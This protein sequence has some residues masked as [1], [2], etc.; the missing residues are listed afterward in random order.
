MADET[1]LPRRDTAERLALVAVPTLLGVVLAATSSAFD[2]PLT[3]LVL[4]GVIGLR[5]SRARSHYRAVRTADGIERRRRPPEE[6]WMYRVAQIDYDERWDRVLA[7]VAL[8][9]GIG[10]FVAVP[11]VDVEP[12]DRARLTVLGLGGI[13]VAAMTY[14][15]L[16]V[17]D[18]AGSENGAGSE[19]TDG[20][21]SE[22]R[23]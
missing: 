19:R 9:V 7:V 16:F 15:S 13:V 21:G 14:G 6:F 8:L 11:V 23:E 17:D 12:M 18:E 5:L 2:H 1:P 20:G 22:L 10:A 3:G 4:G